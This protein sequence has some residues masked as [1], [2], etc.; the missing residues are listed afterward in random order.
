MDALDNTGMGLGIVSEVVVIA[1]V[2]PFTE[3]LVRG[4]AGSRVEA[5]GIVVDAFAGVFVTALG[6]SAK[7]TAGGLYRYTE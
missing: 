3:A 6:R 7:P 1:A 4:A 5:S 2:V